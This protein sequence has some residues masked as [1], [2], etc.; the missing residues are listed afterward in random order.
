MYL[1]FSAESFVIRCPHVQYTTPVLQCLRHTLHCHFGSTLTI[2]QISVFPASMIAT[3]DSSLN[4]LNDCCCSRSFWTASCCGWLAILWI[5]SRMLKFWERFTASSGMPEMLKSMFSSS[6]ARLN[7]SASSRFL[8][9]QSSCTLVVSVPLFAMC[10]RL[11]M[12]CVKMY[13]VCRSHFVYR[14]M[15]VN[16]RCRIYSLYILFHEHKM[17]LWL[18]LFLL[19]SLLGWHFSRPVS[20]QMWQLICVCLRTSWRRKKWEQCECTTVETEN[21]YTPAW[22]KALCT[23]SQSS[24]SPNFLALDRALGSSKCYVKTSAGLCSCSRVQPIYVSLWSFIVL[25]SIG[26]QFAWLRPPSLLRC[27]MWPSRDE[28]KRCTGVLW[29]V[30]RDP[31]VLLRMHW[32]HRI[33]LRT[34]WDWLL[35]VSDFG[36]TSSLLVDCND[37]YS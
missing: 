5:K 10:S 6:V 11:F 9:W 19:N 14:K 13:A 28:L 25:P 20:I 31:E 23:S 30:L 12:L 4:A 24:V 21:T 26:S 16:I 7:L 22:L 32:L 1:R 27:R 17:T 33:V 8:R 36:C 34:N 37:V 35:S 3:F 2:S 18:Y 15:F 29:R